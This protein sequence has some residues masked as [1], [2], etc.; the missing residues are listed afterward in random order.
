MVLCHLNLHYTCSQPWNLKPSGNFSMSIWTSVSSDPLVP[1]MVCQSSL[2]KRKMAHFIYAWVYEP[3]TRLQRK[4]ATHFLS[5]WTSWMH[6]AELESTPRSTCDMLITGF[7]LQK[8]MNGK[9]HFEPTMTCSSGWSCLLASPT[10]L[11]LLN[12]LW[13]TSLETYLITVSSFILVTFWSTLMIQF[14]T[15]NTSERY[16]SDFAKMASSLKQINV[17]GTRIL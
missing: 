12:S 4:T 2:L 16:F 10:H 13:M 17:N 5:F 9:Q 7:T 8:A 3:W 1:C 14:N 11:W 6:L 15:G